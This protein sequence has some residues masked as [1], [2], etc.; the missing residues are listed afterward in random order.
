M[1]SIIA[2]LRLVSMFV[3]SGVLI[4][5]PIGVRAWAALTRQSRSDRTLKRLAKITQMWG[6]MMAYL[7]GV[8]VVRPSEPMPTA[9]LVTSNH[10]SYLDIFVVASLFPGRFV[11]RHDIARWPFIGPL[12]RSV[13]TV[14]I[15]RGRKKE[16]I[17]VGEE[18]RATEDAGVPVIF[19]P[20]GGISDGREVR[21]FHGG[22]LEGAAQAG[23]R[24]LPLCVNYA[25]RESGHDVAETICWADETPLPRHFW[26]L[27]HAG[28]V[29]ATVQWAPTALT[30]P[31]RKSLA[32]GLRDETAS[33]F[34]PLR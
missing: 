1:R 8:R 27:L 2:V 28:G 3:G 5:A 31:D 6:A 33:M 24:V 13:R 10:V 21:P 30:A 17:R 34:A 22:L 29:V 15:E 7:T 32:K 18:M 23:V 25:L 26:R 12:A 9:G 4:C 11:A 16:L 20:E 19:F 14:F